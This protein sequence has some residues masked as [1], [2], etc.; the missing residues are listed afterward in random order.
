MGFQQAAIQELICKDIARHDAV[1]VLKRRYGAQER[2]IAARLG[3]RESEEIIL[4]LPPCSHFLGAEDRYADALSEL[5]KR[6][7]RS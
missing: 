3:E 7:E 6:L 2:R 5:E 1:R 4:T